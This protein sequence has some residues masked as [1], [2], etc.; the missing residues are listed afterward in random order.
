VRNR[1]F[2]L[3]EDYV[4]GQFLPMMNF[5]CVHDSEIKVKLEVAGSEAKAV[6]PPN[7]EPLTKNKRKKKDENK[8][9]A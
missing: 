7:V 2:P 8:D 4:F 3:D 6:L 5:G 9:P 1:G